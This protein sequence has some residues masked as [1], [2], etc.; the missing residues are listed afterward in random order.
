[1]EAIKLFLKLFNDYDN[2]KIKVIFKINSDK[3]LPINITLKY[4]NIE[5]EKL[6]INNDYDNKKIKVIFKINSD[7]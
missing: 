5:I 2:K 7:K 3:K 4:N 6:E 1:M